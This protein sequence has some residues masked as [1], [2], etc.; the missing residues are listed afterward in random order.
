[1]TGTT[2]RTKGG[3]KP[4]SDAGPDGPDFASRSLPEHVVRG[5]VG[6]GALVGSVALIPAVGPVALGLLPIGLLA[7]RGCPT[8]WTIGL[9]QTISR[10][11]LQRSC[12][13]GQCRLTVA[14]QGEHRVL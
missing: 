2:G 12:E 7:L 11:R 4:G 14:G 1:M 5:V 8:C 6:F 3:T 9:M 13:D 10:G